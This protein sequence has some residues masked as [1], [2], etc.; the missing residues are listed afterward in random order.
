MDMTAGTP[1]L[2]ETRAAD[3]FVSP[4][5]PLLVRRETP[6]TRVAAPASPPAR[7]TGRVP[8]VSTRYCGTCGAPIEAGEQYCGQCGTPVSAGSGTEQRT[9]MR[10]TPSAPGR[11]RDDT[12]FDDEKWTPYDNDAPTEAYAPSVHGGFGQS[13]PGYG[14]SMP[15]YTG[16]Y[17]AQAPRGNRELRIVLGILCILGGLVSGAGAIILAIVGH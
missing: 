11:Y 6:P 14:R 8:S 12:G 15:G 5:S 3:A 7:S 17:P 1:S 10:P 4:A 16:A 13:Y 9:A 2:G